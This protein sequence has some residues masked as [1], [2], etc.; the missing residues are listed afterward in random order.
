MPP[1]SWEPTRG[2][3]RSDQ[4]V[5][6]FRPRHVRGAA[7]DGTLKQSHVSKPSVSE[8]VRSSRGHDMKTE[9]VAK[10]LDRNHDEACLEQER[11]EDG[12]YGGRWCHPVRSKPTANLTDGPLTHHNWMEQELSDQDESALLA[13]RV[14]S[15]ITR[16]LQ[17]RHSTLQRLFWC[18]NR[19]CSG[20]L[21]IDEFMEGL[22]KLQ[23]LEYDEVSSLRLLAEAMMLLDPDFDGRVNLP[24]LTRA[25]TAAQAVQR[26]P[27]QALQPKVRS[28][29]AGRFRGST[30]TLASYGAELPVEV[31]KVDKNSKSVCDFNRSRDMF[32]KQQ[33]AML[34]YHGE[35]V[36]PV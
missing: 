31:V 20:V 15:G 30:A 26:K 2:P 19:G 13:S 27:L 34:A 11:H 17:E 14:I 6:D 22:V 9:H 10:Y 28:Q 23:V 8:T 32:H 7:N 33:A 1:R 21:E 3:Q 16:A 35:R 25:V 29:S 4:H 12:N 24:A 18:V 5:N 36:D